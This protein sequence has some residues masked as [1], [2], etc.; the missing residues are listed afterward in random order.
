MARS[1]RPATL[2]GVDD[3]DREHHKEAQRIAQ[4][5]LG[6][7]LDEGEIITGWI[8]SMEVVGP[9][10]RYLAHR[11]GGGADGTEEPKTWIILGMLDAGR[12][13]AEDA[14]RASTVPH[15]DPPDEGEDP[16]P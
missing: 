11:A 7:F 6:A 8:V 10:G 3:Q 1:E 2:A 9:N 16:E 13:E 14:L 15:Y 4:E 12:I 5:A